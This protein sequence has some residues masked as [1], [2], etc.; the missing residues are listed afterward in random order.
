MLNDQTPIEGKG[1]EM[2]PDRGLPFDEMSNEEE[3]SD[4]EFRDFAEPESTEESEEQ[5][6]HESSL[7]ERPMDLEEDQAS[8]ESV[9][10]EI[11]AA[12]SSQ[13]LDIE[14]I[15]GREQELSEDS[16]TPSPDFDGEP[17]VDFAAARTPVP[18]PSA[19]REAIM[20]ESGAGVLDK[21]VLTT[22]EKEE[23]VREEVSADLFE[24]GTISVPT[25]TPIPG[26]SVTEREVF[27]EESSSGKVMFSKET[28]EL[29]GPISDHDDVKA[30]E[31]AGDL[32]A[33]KKMLD[34]LVT[35]KRVEELWGR[36]DDLQS[37]IID[38]IEDIGV[39]RT[40][41]NHI[42]SARTRLLEKKDNYEEAERELNE[43]EFRLSYS[44]R[45]RQWRGLG[46]G[47]L[48]YEIAWGIILGIF[49]GVLISG[50]ENRLP[51]QESLLV[52]K[53]EIF[54]GLGGIIWG[55]IGGVIGA[56]HALWRYI[57]TQK[58]NPQFN[59]WYLAQPVMGLFIGAFIFL[60][61]KIAFNVTAGNTTA[62]I[63]SPWM[64]YL[65]G[66]I[67]G[68]QQNVL[69]DIVKQMLKLFQ[70]GKSESSSTDPPA[71]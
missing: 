13:L 59:I 46:Y 19:D 61:I 36:A 22:D 26:S 23:D 8:S 25:P 24:T 21:D 68:F 18:L 17:D 39:A 40:L 2:I 55:G 3:S 50:G 47:L 28:L 20:L 52:S 15:R 7:A 65:F 63:G 30:P 35:N 42:R 34:L 14:E 43:V 5:A 12:I 31:T 37:Q 69:Y 4:F 58:F 67:A 44:L 70:I 48:V 60:F 57:T 51:I 38:N 56:L 45:S 1:D 11:Q 64:V 6:P 49:L 32:K 41:L 54:I 10:S 62:E 66:F 16:C 53:A 71:G 29:P 33:A 9:A 27:I